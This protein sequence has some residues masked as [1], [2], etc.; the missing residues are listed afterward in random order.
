MSAAP[1]YRSDAKGQ[2]A[3]VKAECV[4]TM[5]NCIANADSFVLLAEDCECYD[6][7]AQYLTAPELATCF[8]KAR[9]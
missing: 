8:K 9:A 3:E 2:I 5:R 4:A 1:K 7:Y 6:E